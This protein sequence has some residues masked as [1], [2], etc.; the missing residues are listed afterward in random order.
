MDRGFLWVIKVF[1]N[2]WDAT[3]YLVISN[4]NLPY[5]LSLW[6]HIDGLGII[7]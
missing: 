4:A 5:K 7:F 3:N 1:Q 6:N 2:F